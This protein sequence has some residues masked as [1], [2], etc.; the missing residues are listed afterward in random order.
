MQRGGPALRPALQLL[1]FSRRLRRELADPCRPVAECRTCT[2]S[3]RGTATRAE[4]VVACATREE[5]AAP[6]DVAARLGDVLAR[7]PDRVP[8]HG[9]RAVIAP[10]GAWRVADLRLVA[11][12]AVV[13]HG[14]CATRNDVPGTDACVRVDRRVGSARVHC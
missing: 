14:S 6:G 7:D 9:C 8:D 1:R 11:R 13:L 12:E 4:Q 10:A 3:M 2:R 5:R